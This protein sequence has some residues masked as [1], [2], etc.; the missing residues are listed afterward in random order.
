MSDAVGAEAVALILA[1]SWAEEMYLYKVVFISDCLQL[2]QHNNGV[3]TSIAWRSS[4]FLVQCRKK[5]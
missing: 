2:V 4:D 1:I 3:N 5:I